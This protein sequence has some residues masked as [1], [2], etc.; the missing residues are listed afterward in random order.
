MALPP[1]FNEFL[2]GTG[3]DADDPVARTAYGDYIAAAFT[4][5]NV[6]FIAWWADNRHLY[7]KPF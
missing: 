3:F 5:P 4:K 7:G 1:F 6:T 2:L